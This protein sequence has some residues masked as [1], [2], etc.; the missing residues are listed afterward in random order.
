MSVYSEVKRAYTEKTRK[1]D[2]LTS[3]PVRAISL[4]VVL[5]A[6]GQYNEFNPSR[7]AR[8]IMSVDKHASVYV[9]REGSPALYIKTTPGKAP[10]MRAALKAARAD[11]IGT[12]KGY[13]RAWWD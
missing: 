5:K 13:I 10:R 6:I 7:V 11:E 1:L 8:A 4:P 2:F 3:R 9:G 12:K